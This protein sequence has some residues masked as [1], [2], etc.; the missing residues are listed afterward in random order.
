MNYTLIDWILFLS[1]ILFYNIVVYH[2]ALL[3]RIYER[4][5]IPM[6]GG[7]YPYLSKEYKDFQ[8][9]ESESQCK[10]LPDSYVVKYQY[11][12]NDKIIYSRGGIMDQYDAMI[13]K[14]LFLKYNW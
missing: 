4:R 14:Y 5:F 1:A 11:E 12:P 8:I 10:I 2:I 3:L 7:V 13:Y 6:Q 9:R